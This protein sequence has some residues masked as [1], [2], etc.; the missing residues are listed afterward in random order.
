M[1]R[2]ERANRSRRTQA[3]ACATFLVWCS[4]A[5]AL[6]P[7]LDISQYA[8]TAWT[9]RDGYFNGII[10]GGITQTPGRLPVVRDGIRPG[11]PLLMAFGSFRGN[12]SPGRGIWKSVAFGALLAARDGRLWIGGDNGLAS[13]KDGQLIQYPQVSGSFILSL[14][15]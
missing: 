7:S 4:C 1:Q 13:W 6:N 5:F 10:L 8:H 11:S 15:E 9:I 2:V 14:L 12:R 3:K